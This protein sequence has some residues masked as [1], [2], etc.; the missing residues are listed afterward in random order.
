[1]QT[2]DKPY[3][4][5]AFQPHPYSWGLP[6]TP[7][8]LMPPPGRCPKNKGGYSWR[9]DAA[10]TDPQI[11]GRNL[12]RGAE[13]VSCSLLYHPFPPIFVLEN[14]GTKGGWEVTGGRLPAPVLPAPALLGSGHPEGAEGVG[15]FAV[16][17]H[18]GGVYPRSGHI[19][20]RRRRLEAP[21]K[22]KPERF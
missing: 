9:L 17:R 2:A 1:M 13:T 19:G 3:R 7:G 21:L 20:L 15:E 22:R 6:P 5:P 16:V 12:E 8:R 4:A 18:A 14:G 10:S 11:E